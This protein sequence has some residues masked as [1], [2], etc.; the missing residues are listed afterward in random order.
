V[1]NDFFVLLTFSPS[2]QNVHPI[3]PWGCG[4][5]IVISPGTE[6]V[7]LLH[8][9]LG[10]ARIELVIADSKGIGAGYHFGE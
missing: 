8:S 4:W 3:L 10:L 6:H 2:A 9:V 1:A 5:R 7:T